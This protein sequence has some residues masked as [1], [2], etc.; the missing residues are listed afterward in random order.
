M[1]NKE[2]MLISIIAD[3]RQSKPA[4]LFYNSLIVNSKQRPIKS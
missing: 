1:W 3:N 4:S 2:K